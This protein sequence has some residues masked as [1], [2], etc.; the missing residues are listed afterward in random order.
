M[1]VPKTLLPRRGYGRRDEDGWSCSDQSH[2]V[3]TVCILVSI[4]PRRDGTFRVSL[5]ASRFSGVFTNVSAPI[6]VDFDRFSFP[7]IFGGFGIKHLDALW[8]FKDVGR[9]LVRGGGVATK[10]GPFLLL[11]A[12]GTGLTSTPDGKVGTLFSVLDSGTTSTVV[13]L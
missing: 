13:K 10:P 7:S 11:L 1:G 4:P 8:T 6:M 2:A 12:A 5:K 9:L 3:E